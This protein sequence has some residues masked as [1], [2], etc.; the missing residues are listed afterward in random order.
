L[1]KIKSTEKINTENTAPYKNIFLNKFLFPLRKYERIR[2][3]DSKNNTTYLGV[4]SIVEKK[5][6]INPM[7]KFI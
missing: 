6:I 1:L 2:P 3:R 7:K 4:K 5:I